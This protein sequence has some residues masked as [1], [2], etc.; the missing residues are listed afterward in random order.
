MDGPAGREPASQ[1]ATAKARLV[2]PAAAAVTALAAPAAAAPV[3][4][5]LGLVDR[6]GTAPHL[7]AAQGGDGGLGLLVTA[8]LHEAEPLGAAGVPVHDDLGRLHRAVLPE[9]LLQHAV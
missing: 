2:P 7:L 6:Q 5:G 9:H 8:H 3:L 1:G 4:A